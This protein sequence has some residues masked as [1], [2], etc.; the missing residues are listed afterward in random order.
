MKKYVLFALI[1]LFILALITSCGG[2]G[3]GGGGAVALQEKSSLHNGGDAGGWGSSGG[4]GNSVSNGG[5]NNEVEV[6]ITG[7]TPLSVEHYEYNGVT[8]NTAKE[9]VNVLSAST[10]PDSFEVDF[11][12]ENE[13]EPRKARVSANGT[14]GNGQDIFIEHQYMATCSLPDIDG[15]PGAPITIP[16]YKRDGISLADIANA[17]GNETVGS[18][19]EAVLFELQKLKIGTT[20]YDKN[21]NLPVNAAGDVTLDGNS[22]KGVYEKWGISQNKTIQFSSSLENGDAIA[23]STNEQ[24]TKIQLPGGGKVIKL[25]L[26]NMA[27]SNTTFDSNLITPMSFVSE[28]VLPNG[29][30]TIAGYTFS[31][32]VRL[33]S[34]TLSDSVTTIEE[35]AFQDCSTLESVNL[36][37]GLTTLDTM[38]FYGCSS[39]RSI[40]IP[41]SLETIGDEAFEGCSALASLTIQNGVKNIGNIA[42][43]DCSSLETVV[44]PDSVE[45]IGNAA[46]LRCTELQNV[47][48]PTNSAFT[49]LSTNLFYGCS[50]LETVNIPSSVTTINQGA[51]KDCAKL[52]NVNADNR[53]ELPSSI[54]TIV[55]GAF[56]NSCSDPSLAPNGVSL[57]F[58]SDPI[59]GQDAFKGCTYLTSIRSLADSFTLAA[60]AFSDCSNLKELVLS[61]PMTI[62]INSNMFSGL[63]SGERVSIT[64]GSLRMGSGP[65]IQDKSITLSGTS[66]FEKTPHFNANTG[67]LPGQFS[68]TGSTWGGKYVIVRSG[69]Y[70]TWNG[71]TWS[72]DAIAP[73]EWND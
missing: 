13:T 57:W 59:L 45:T 20:E 28:L 5:S 43:S 41:S 34:V 31:S 7:G 70:S 21:G 63:N 58:Y 23:I 69:S 24:I 65:D 29:I 26:R 61:N 66:T 67:P 33:T 6:I 48:L 40:T 15:M 14:A 55:Q 53:I 37:N 9:L 46:F 49:E 17:I 50:N 10:L 12:V 27:T 2:G 54:T 62:T 22:I 18:G 39:L 8:Y 36:P 11:Y 72:S 71:S 3:G 60:N 25:D 38:A 73:A 19:T 32:A 1:Y 68:I 42:F 51:F 35:R 30:D 16:F 47:T 44:I 56:E 52:R 64:L 4:G